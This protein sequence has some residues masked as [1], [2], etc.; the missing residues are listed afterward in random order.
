MSITDNWTNL[1]YSVVASVSFL[2]MFFDWLWCHYSVCQGSHGSPLWP[3][4]VTIESSI[5]HFSSHCFLTFLKLIL[6]SCKY[7]F[8][9]NHPKQI[10]SFIHDI[11][12]TIKLSQAWNGR[13]MR[14]QNVIKVSTNKRSQTVQTITKLVGIWATRLQSAIDPWVEAAQ[15]LCAADSS[16]LHWLNLFA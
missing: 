5:S 11:G 8:H 14:A 10:I 6:D 7:L 12:L 1:M 4:Q 15:S 16:D 3:W 2:L 13:C 9:N